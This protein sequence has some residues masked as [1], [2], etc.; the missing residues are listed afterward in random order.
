MGVFDALQRKLQA[1]WR[2]P[3]SLLF[4]GGVACAADVPKSYMEAEAIWQESRTSPAYQSYVTEFVQLN[5]L[6]R[7]DEQDNCYSLASGTV[8][9]M[10]VV[11]SA[12]ASGV[13]K[14]ERVYF[15]TDNAK[16]RCFERSFTGLPAK[17]APFHPFVIQLSM[18]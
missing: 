5:N 6:F 10:L 16:A 4:I 12:E 14:I 17:P 18:E 1:N 15:D 2:A 3:V 11:S 8:N 7:V 13:A 9:L